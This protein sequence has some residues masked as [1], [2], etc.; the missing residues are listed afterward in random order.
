MKNLNKIVLGFILLLTVSAGVLAFW[1]AGQQ[2]S[3]YEDSL[4]SGYD[5]E[6][7]ITTN[8][9]L[10]NVTLYLPIPVRDNTSSVGQYIAENNFTSD[11]PA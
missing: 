5:Y 4:Y 1:W 8:S 11:D 6:V 3:M 9:N 10:S 7:T 2:Q